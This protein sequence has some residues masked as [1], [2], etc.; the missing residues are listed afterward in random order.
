MIFEI[1]RELMRRS[2]RHSLGGDEDADPPAESRRQSTSSRQSRET[3]LLYP[4]RDR[5]VCEARQQRPQRPQ[6][7]KKKKIADD[8]GDEDNDY[9]EEDVED[10]DEDDD[11]GE[12]DASGDCEAAPA[13]ALMDDGRRQ[14]RRKSAVSYKEPNL[15]DIRRD[16][17]PASNR[18]KRGDQI[19]VEVD[20]DGSGTTTWQSAEVVKLLGN[21]RFRAMVNG[22]A[23]FVEEYGPEDEGQ[24]WRRASKYDGLKRQRKS[25]EHYQ[26]GEVPRGGPSR[27]G[28]EM[29][30]SSVVGPFR[31][32]GGRVGVGGGR[33]GGGGGERGGGRR[34]GGSSRRHAGSESDTLSSEEEFERRKKKSEQRLRGNV[35]PL[36]HGG[37][38]GGSSGA[39]AAASAR[40]AAKASRSPAAAVLQG[41]LDELTGARGG[42]GSGSGIGDA[43]AAAGGAKLADV[44]P[45][46]VDGTV[47]W[48][49]VGGLGAHVEALKEMVLIPLLYPE[50][51]EQLGVTP[52]RGVLFH[53]PPGTGKTLV[54]RA[55]ASTCSSAGRP[56]A[57]FMRKGADV[58]SKWV[59]E[60]EKQLRLLFDEATR[61]QPAIIFFDELDG[62]A[63]VRSSKQ[64]YIHASIVST[65]LALMDGLDSR[66][67]VLLIGATNRIDA[68]D[69]ALRRPGRFDRELQIS[70]PSCM[71]VLT[72]TLHPLPHR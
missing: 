19:E 9:E 54:A 61:L 36:N 55:L 44:Q 46:K 17:S 37:G 7:Q 57:F 32:G 71:H 21:D 56:V 30:L 5:G 42:G 60:A 41:A 52:P 23:E 11:D 39:P 43:F 3:W 50:I 31:V 38:G 70:L 65:L 22:D 8:D 53:G 20:V 62:L 16:P 10:D 29:L 48:D 15:H 72:T 35:A 47:G 51:F 12:R 34:R 67:Q 33:D 2:A 28:E 4:G 14:T 64:D 27:A 6:A 63:P 40:P 25:V 58:L 18:L 26:P 24:E 13:A 68:L 1:W 49:Q 45:L 69:S 59:G 66:G